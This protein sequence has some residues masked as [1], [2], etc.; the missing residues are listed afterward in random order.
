LA[1][2]F[3]DADA[4]RGKRVA[5]GIARQLEAKYPSAAASLR[6]GLDDMFAVR[7]L[8]V[9][10]RLARSLSCT[11]SIESMFSVVRTVTGRVKTWKDTQMVRRWVAA[12]MLEAERS[13]RRIKGC[14]D[15][16]TL[17]A[18]VHAE[19]ARRVAADTPPAQDAVA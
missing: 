10:D 19:V 4:A 7:R 11:N 15:M 13:F 2:A 3:N 5:E 18:A 12:G 9:S 8:G 16:G 1:K 14:N 17:V 6:E